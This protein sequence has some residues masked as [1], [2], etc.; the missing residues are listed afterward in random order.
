MNI[1]SLFITLTFVL[2]IFFSEALAQDV[3]VIGGAKY[4]I[5]NVV[6]GETLYSLARQY[7]V[8][9]DNIVDANKFLVDGLKAG[10]RIKIPMKES[11]T[12]ATSAP[13]PTPATAPAVLERRP[14]R[15][16]YFSSVVATQ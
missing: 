6:K 3:V 1:R 9:V 14:P 15:T 4:S 8:T 12:V 7:G 11:A 5:H 13:A 2:S 16:R 10:Q